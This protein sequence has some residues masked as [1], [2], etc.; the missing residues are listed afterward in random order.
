M[1]LGTDTAFRFSRVVSLGFICPHLSARFHVHDCYFF[2]TLTKDGL[3]LAL[4]AEVAREAL[5][6]A[7][8]VVTDAASGAV[9]A[10]LVTVSQEDVGAGRALL[11]GAVRSAVP[12]IALEVF[13]KGE[14]KKEK[15]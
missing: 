14:E 8:G 13:E 3:V 5:A 7:R 10:L 11:E 6:E 1:D 12:K 15:L 2:A 9:A 4:G